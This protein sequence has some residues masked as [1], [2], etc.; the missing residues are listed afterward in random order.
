MWRKNI[1]I[2]NTFS[3]SINLI[4]REGFI[5]SIAL[6]WFYFPEWMMLDEKEMSLS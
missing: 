1:C 4:K 2:I 6:A 3:Y 5:V